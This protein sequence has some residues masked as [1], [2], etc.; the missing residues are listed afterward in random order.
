MKIPPEIETGPLTILAPTNEAFEQ[1]TPAARQL[2]NSD[3]A[4]LADIIRGHIVEGAQFG[5]LI[6]MRSQLKTM[7]SD[8]T[9]E[10]KVI[11]RK[12][13]QLLPRNH[14]IFSGAN[15]LTPRNDLWR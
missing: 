5:K 14:R 11:K 13:T 8:Q 3:P 1:L 15:R 9:I 4:A 7:N 6:P 2:I 10:A 12:L